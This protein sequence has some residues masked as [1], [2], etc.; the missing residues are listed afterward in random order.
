MQR[1]HL[2]EDSA[3]KSQNG[4]VW[5][6]IDNDLLDFHV[7]VGPRHAIDDLRF[8]LGFAKSWGLS[9][10]DQDECEPEILSGGRIRLY[11]KTLN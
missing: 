3:T 8:V 4:G 5:L 9:L 1:S 11:L 6:H 2:V 7:T 10:L